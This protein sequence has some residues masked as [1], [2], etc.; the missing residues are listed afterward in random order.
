M[1]YLNAVLVIVE[2]CGS[3]VFVVVRMVGAAG[4]AVG[5]WEGVLLCQQVECLGEWLVLHLL[6]CWLHHWGDVPASLE[7][8][9]LLPQNDLCSLLWHRAVPWLWLLH[10]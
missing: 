5:L 10:L 1:D 4:T 6:P 9:P 7:D 8:L 3:P 2:E